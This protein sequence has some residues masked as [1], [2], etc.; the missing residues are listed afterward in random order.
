MSN[1]STRLSVAS[2]SANTSMKRN[3]RRISALHGGEVV[4]PHVVANYLDLWGK[5]DGFKEFTVLLKDDR[6]VAVR[7]QG[8]KH[9]PQ[10][11]RAG[12]DRL[13][14]HYRPSWGREVLVALFKVVE[15][16]G[17]F[18]GELRSDRKI[19]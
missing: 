5:D 14:W 19:A 4:R 7:G 2:W 11:G 15:V 18:H 10:S 13:L 6:V 3:C 1:P 16:I 9:S 17:I 8:L 12:R